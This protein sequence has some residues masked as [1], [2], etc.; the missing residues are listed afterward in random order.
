MTGSSLNLLNIRKTPPNGE[1][2]L[3]PGQGFEPRLPVPETGV[4]P[5]DDPGMGAKNIRDFFCVVNFGACV[6]CKTKSRPEAAFYLSFSLFTS[7]VYYDV[8]TFK[9]ASI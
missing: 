2:F 5:L 1:V 4:L 6:L 9:V 3:V 7:D 8:A